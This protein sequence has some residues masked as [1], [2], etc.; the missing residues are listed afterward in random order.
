MT[1]GSTA[2]TCA[3]RRSTCA[4]WAPARCRPRAA[5]SATR[6]R[7]RFQNWLV[8]R[9]RADV[10]TAMLSRWEHNGVPVY[11]GLAASPRMTKPFQLALLKEAGLPVPATRWTND[12]DE[13]HSFA[14]GAR[15][16][17]KPV[18]GGA[19]TRELGSGR[20]GAVAARSAE[21]RAGHFPELAARR[22]HSR[23]RARWRGDRCHPHRHARAGLSRPRG[24][25]RADRVA[26]GRA[27]TVHSRGA[28][29]RPALHRHGLEAR[30]GGHVALSGA[31]RLADVPG[32][33]CAGRHRHR[34]LRWR[35]DWRAG[36]PGL[37]APALNRQ[38]WPRPVSRRA[39][40]RVQ[41]G[42]SPS[43]GA[44][45]S[46]RA[47]AAPARDTSRFR[48]PSQGASGSRRARCASPPG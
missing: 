43:V 22:G 45:R 3:P 2:R 31:E 5:P 13:V 24:A 37:L 25:L 21:P 40:L 16:A 39:P 38:C 33:R 23:V 48:V 28:G 12:P 35:R 27:A 7:E 14:V 11:N 9:E 15:V 1:C 20:S 47:C 10:L 32:L 19:A 46:G 26:H 18:S 44:S 41:S 8:G 36:C 30:L 17:Y 29:H 4:T 6:P 42:A 34:G